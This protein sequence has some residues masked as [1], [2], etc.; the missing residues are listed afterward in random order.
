MYALQAF[1]ATVAWAELNNRGRQEAHPSERVTKDI[2]R[3]KTAIALDYRSPYLPGSTIGEYPRADLRS[4]AVRHFCICDV[5][6]PRP[7]KSNFP[8][9]GHHAWPVGVLWQKAAF[10]SE[11]PIY[12]GCNRAVDKFG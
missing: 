1:F 2:E 12:V 10:F 3:T 5:E 4:L 11:S 8:S 6:H 9:L 7:S